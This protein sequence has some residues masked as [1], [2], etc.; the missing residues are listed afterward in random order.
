MPA[1]CLSNWLY[2]HKKETPPIILIRS[3][4]T[5]AIWRFS[6]SDMGIGIAPAHFERIFDIFQRLHTEE[7]IEGS[8]IGLANCKKIIQLHGGEIWVE[9]KPEQGTT[10]HFTIP[11]LTL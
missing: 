7:K 4:K 9:S 8:G 3:E 6:V 2:F 5:N 10:F 11:N 1:T